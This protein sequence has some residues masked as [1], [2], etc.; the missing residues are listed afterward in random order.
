MRKGN[1]VNDLEGRDRIVILLINRTLPK[2]NQK[3]Q[4]MLEKCHMILLK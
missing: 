1:L 2:V 4:I 3:L